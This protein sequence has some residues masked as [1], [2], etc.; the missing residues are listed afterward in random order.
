MS[1]WLLR[2]RVE[3]SLLNPALIGL[4]IAHAATGYRRDAQATMPWPMV[5][6]I[7]P[8]VL[9]RPTRDELPANTRTHFATWVTHHPQLVAGFPRRALV[10]AEP[11]REGVRLALRTRQLTIVDAR[12]ASSQLAHPPAGE[13]RQLLRTAT[14]VG[15]W[16]ARLDQPST[17][18][19]LLG[20]AP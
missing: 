6:L 15:R 2:P 13:L 17:A 4:S 9:H 19:A 14:L 10:M 8:I 7:P 11:T 20:V 3:A 1:D 16:F 5:F 12:V 18:F